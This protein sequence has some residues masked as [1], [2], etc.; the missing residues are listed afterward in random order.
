MD[1][2]EP[3]VSGGEA[4]FGDRSSERCE[5]RSDDATSQGPAADLIA[6]RLR[7]LPQVQR[8]LEQP[9]A[10]RLARAS[11][12]SAVAAAFRTVLDHVRAELRSGDIETPTVA[13][14]V[15]RAEALIAFRG[16]A[17]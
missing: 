5:A 1:K 16:C 15:D 3:Q 2:G 14:L 9:E 11:S 10:V 8:L 12:R 13:D 4:G 17:V 7:A 6:S